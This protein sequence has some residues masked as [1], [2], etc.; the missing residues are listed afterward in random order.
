M[1]KMILSTI[2]IAGV[3]SAVGQGTV[4]F[5]NRT[6]SGAAFV[7]APTGALIGANGTGGQYG[8]ATTLAQ[9]LGAPGS[10]AP[11]SSLVAQIGSPVSFR[12]GTAAGVVVTSVATFNNI[13]P[14]APFGS[15]EMV[16]WDNSSALYPTWAE[17]SIALHAG[18]IPAGKSGE[19]VI[20]NIG[21][22]V[23]NPPELFPGLTTFTLTLEPSTTAFVCLGTALVILRGRCPAHR[24]G[25]PHGS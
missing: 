6:S 5:N 14:D 9:L 17:A 4:I 25:R 22:N 10:N 2:I 18:L 24:L 8:A 21:G 23:N 11:E 12:T 3:A 16:A 7:Y 15:F 13:S 20:Q 19:F 1:K